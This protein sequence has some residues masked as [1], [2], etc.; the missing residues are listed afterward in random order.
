MEL[1]EEDRVPLRDE[2]SVVA[3]GHINNEQYSV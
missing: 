2:W 1:I 3:I